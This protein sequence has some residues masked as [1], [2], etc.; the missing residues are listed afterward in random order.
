MPGLKF[1]LILL[2]VLVHRGGEIETWNVLEHPGW[3]QIVSNWSLEVEAVSSNSVTFQSPREQECNQTAPLWVEIACKGSGDEATQSFELPEI[4]T[5]RNLS[6]GTE[7]QCTAR[8]VK[9]DEASRW[10]KKQQVNFT[11]QHSELLMGRVAPQH[12]AD[13]EEPDKTRNSQSPQ[14]TIVATKTGD[15]TTSLI[16]CLAVYSVVFALAIVI[17]YNCRRDPKNRIPRQRQ[18]Q[19]VSE[20]ENCYDCEGR[21]PLSI[22][23][24]YYAYVRSS[25][26][27]PSMM[28]STETSFHFPSPL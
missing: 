1:N 11:T 12:V 21:A 8:L 22:R 5:M 24:V 25:L 26:I 3:R 28:T 18:R 15:A 13:T 6:G 10:N 7:Y 4:L 16:I 14:P 9:E 19:K 17:V 2:Q 27:A 23:I 20:L